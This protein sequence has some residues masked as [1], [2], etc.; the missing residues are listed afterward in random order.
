MK[1]RAVL[2]FVLFL[3]VFMIGGVSAEIERITNWNS[4][5]MDDYRLYNIQV[6][7]DTLTI[8]P[9]NMGDIG[10]PSANFKIEGDFNYNIKKITS[11]FGEIKT[12]HISINF[13][14]QWHLRKY[15][16]SSSDLY[17]RTLSVRTK[18]IDYGDF[19]FIDSENLEYRGYLSGIRETGLNDGCEPSLLYVGNFEAFSIDGKKKISGAIELEIPTNE[20][21]GIF[22]EPGTFAGQSV[23]FNFQ[24]FIDDTQKRIS[25][26]ES[27][28]QTIT[29]IISNIWLAITGHTIR[30]ENLEN[31]TYPSVNLTHPYF[32]Y[33]SSS[34]R[35]NIV[36]GYAEDN[37]LNY[38]ADLGWACN[39]T[40]RVY[41]GGERAYCRCKKI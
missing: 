13:Y 9:D 34:D 28:K 24:G 17:D 14:E 7:P 33:L 11:D 5:G 38:L 30:I 1:K 2:I 3:V 18:Y 37:H 12:G 23:K 10:I 16:Y 26:L 20:T 41:S 32:K 31:Q 25:T 40:Y 6:N 36:C 27:W 29:D 15:C 22:V 8:Q 19:K 4:Y 21:G 35:K 39:V